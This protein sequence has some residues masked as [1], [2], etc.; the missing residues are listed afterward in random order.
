M[1]V[2]KPTCVV[3]NRVLF[4]GCKVKVGLTLVAATYMNLNFS[5]YLGA[6][7]TSQKNIG[8]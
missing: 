1:V 8:I 6:N 4:Q 5:V 2:C 3:G 7:F